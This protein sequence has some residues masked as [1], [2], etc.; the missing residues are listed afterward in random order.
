MYPYYYYKYRYSFYYSMRKRH[1]SQM[2]PV[3]DFKS[4]RINKANFGMNKLHKVESVLK[5]ISAWHSLQANVLH[6]RQ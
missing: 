2:S 3:L 1:L 5:S 4:M 6:F